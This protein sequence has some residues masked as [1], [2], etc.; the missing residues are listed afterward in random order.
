M[1]ATR[2]YGKV[3]HRNLGVQELVNA[4]LERGQGTLT[5]DGALVVHTRYTGRTPKDKFIVLDDETR[6]TF[7][8]GSVNQPFDP[9]KFDALEAKLRAYYAKREVFVQD[10]SVGRM[11]HEMSVRVVNELPYHN[12]FVR[13]LFIPG[14]KPILG[15]PDWTILS[16]PNLMADPTVDGTR[17][18]AFIIINVSR[19][20]TII[21]GTDYAGE[22][23]KSMFGVLQYV[24]PPRGVL[25]MHCSA[26]EGPDGD[27]ALFFG[28]SGTGKTTLSADPQRLLLGDDEHGW[29]PEGIFN[30][31]GG[32]YAKA[33]DLRPETEPEIYA[34]TRQYGT[35]MENVV[36][37]NG[38]PDFTN[39]SRTENTR[40]AYPLSAVPHK[41]EATGTHPRHIFFLTADATGALPPIARLNRAQAM[42][43][44]LLGY[45]SKLAGTEVGV[46]EP[47]PVFSTCFG[48]PFLSR[49]PQVYAGMLGEMIDTHGSTV[50]LVNTGWAGGAY[51]DAPRMALAET[52]ALLTQAMAGA[53]TTFTSDPVFGFEVPVSVT[54]QAQR[55]A[56][57]E[58]WRTAASELK[59]RFDAEL[60]KLA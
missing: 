17:S 2:T 20:L 60:A 15:E 51:G 29:G 35:I 6:D 36:A 52:R 31:E 27:T 25:S 56:S 43:M 21:G 44:F 1:Q 28:L 22:Q 26:N 10:L 47:Q 39:V 19:R 45:T 41:P 53:F 54:P 59:A 18:E 48:A 11:G 14:G 24:L 38:E 23:K 12:L 32:C 49:H 33:I 13:H 8:W 50:W 40:I 55:W 37:V 3:E 58:Q 9:G 5:N 34:T 30:F 4:V 46:K 57:A 16:A 7:W 42:E